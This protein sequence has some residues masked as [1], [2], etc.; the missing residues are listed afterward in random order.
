MDHDNSRPQHKSVQTQ[1]SFL[2]S[3]LLRP[4]L[5]SVLSGVPR[6]TTHAQLQAEPGRE[7][8]ICAPNIVRFSLTAPIPQALDA[9][10]LATT[11][12]K[13][14]SRVRLSSGEVD[15]DFNVNSWFLKLRRLLK[16][17][18][19]SQIS[20]ILNMDGDPQGVPCSAF[21]GDEPPVVVR[22]LNF[23]TRK[24]R[25][26]SWYMGFTNGLFRVCRPSHVWGD[27]LM[28]G[29][30]INYRLSEF[31]L[32]I[33]LANK[34]LRTEPYFW[35]HDLEQVHV[36]GQFVQYTNLSQLRNRTYDGIV[37]LELKWRGQTSR[38]CET[39][40]MTGHSTALACFSVYSIVYMPPAFNRVSYQELVT[41]RCPLSDG[42]VAM[43]L[44]LRSLMARVC[45]AVTKGSTQSSA[46]G[47][48]PPDARG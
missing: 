23:S 17:L 48:S 5:G 1:L 14:Y 2:F 4:A 15:P 47:G 6:R 29:S 43:K 9:F 10:S 34:S 30:D 26:A 36:D 25:T 7:L 20:L 18:S 16:A 3:G 41:T 46:T 12:K 8:T 38:N 24:C 11:S 13:W 35:Q 44:E 28:S 27:S 39:G 19:G 45:L 21:L 32:N 33:L 42:V 40:H 37:C 31:Q 22:S